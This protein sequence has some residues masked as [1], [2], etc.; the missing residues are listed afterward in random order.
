[1]Q[2][3]K[4][5]AELVAW[6]SWCEAH[7]Y[8]DFDLFAMERGMDEGVR[9]E[10]MRILE[11]GD[12]LPRFAVDANISQ[13][14]TFTKELLT[15]EF[16][17]RFDFSSQ[18]GAG[19]MGSVWLA[20]QTEPIQR[21]VAV[22]L[23]RNDL[24]SGSMRKRFAFEQ[25]ALASL[26]HQNIAT[27]HEAGETESGRSYFVMEY[28]PGEKITDYCNQYR[29]N[30][31]ARLELF[32]QVCDAVE[33]A[34]RKRMIHRDLKPSNVIVM[35]ENGEP[36]A[37][38]IDFGLAKDVT[39]VLDS[40]PLTRTNAVIGSPMWMSPEQARAFSDGEVQVDTR[41]DVYSLGVILYEL[42]TNS[43]P[44]RS[45]F[46]RSAPPAKVFDAIRSQVPVYPSNRL[47]A[48]QID[49]K[50]W[51]ESSSDSNYS[52]W[53]GSLKN[54]L[55]WVVM[56]ALEKEPERRYGTISEFVNDLKRFMRG[57][58]VS[59]RPPS[60]FYQ[61][62]KLVGRNRLAV[63]SMAVVTAALLVSVCVS[64]GYAIKADHARI[65]AEK[66]L[67][68]SEKTIDG[69]CSGFEVFSFNDQSVEN[70]KLKRELIIKF[71][72][73]VDL[74]LDSLRSE[75]GPQELARL[76]YV[77]GQAFLK[78]L[79][80]AD[81]HH[82][83]VAQ[84]R[85]LIA[86]LSPLVEPD[87]ERLVRSRGALAS[88][89]LFLK[90]RE[91][92]VKIAEENFSIIKR[93][94]DSTDY[95][96]LVC[97][98]MWIAASSDTRALAENLDMLERVVENLNLIDSEDGYSSSIEAMDLASQLCIKAS[99]YD[100]AINW[101]DKARKLSRRIHGDDIKTIQLD[102]KHADYTMSQNGKGVDLDQL[103]TNYKTVLDRYGESHPV[104]LEH[105]MFYGT[106]LVNTETGPLDE[107]IALIRN[108]FEISEKELGKNHL[109]TCKSRLGLV[110]SLYF[111]RKYEQARDAYET[112]AEDFKRYSSTTREYEV[113]GWLYSNALLR[114][115]EFEP[116]FKVAKQFQ[117]KRGMAKALVK[118]N[119]LGEAMKILEPLSESEPKSAAETAELLV[120][121][122]QIVS[123][124]YAQGN[125]E[126][127][128]ETL[129]RH[130]LLAPTVYPLTH[131]Y[132]IQA[133]ALLQ[134]FHA[135]NGDRE[136]SVR[137][138]LQLLDTLDSLKNNFDFAKASFFSACVECLVQCSLELGNYEDV[139]RY[140]STYLEYNTSFPGVPSMD[141]KL[142]ELTVEAKI[143]QSKYKEAEKQLLKWLS[144]LAIKQPED[145]QI[146]VV[147]ARKKAYLLMEKVYSASG[148][149][150]KA[151]E[152]R[153]KANELAK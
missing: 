148:Q 122:R 120:T 103:A 151:I 92:S 47:S 40:E 53:V 71:G 44:M 39:N 125:L 132:C 59:A 41:T 48:S 126:K 6:D 66:R 23:I 25:Q 11:I 83:I 79:R 146:D 68:I 127:A 96:Y 9:S 17:N 111:A 91:D 56:K 75:L 7:E 8:A 112:Y 117:D 94:F 142:N 128:I 22:K 82:E 61:F 32:L 97:E 10:L 42:L 124:F 16:G 37:K 145:N 134:Q 135:E 33:H 20:E 4:I 58:S 1:M 107:G 84:L 70:N 54:D 102:L 100:L 104:T 121:L 129:N 52:S 101:Y 34:H 87:D 26:S 12:N 43:T 38:V 57:E 153:L 15:K 29:L 80:S 90:K 27:V 141:A 144:R 115:G 138:G 55:D 13:S 60:R 119:R 3:N 152:F 35:E 99:E 62:K 73:R 81:H 85:Q 89:L 49:S 95:L 74:E 143:R 106:F 123:V 98:R 78:V 110:K 130:Q 150:A 116:S 69:F 2:E 31:R 36:V 64:T 108:A 113:A 24:V 50:S 133:Q 131:K 28:I 118:L 63:A 51:V 76:E 86:K 65:L 137:I 136:D 67:E 140:A 72:N 109:I 30:L 19:G 105:Q 5:D 139:D 18:L 21:N 77:W 149:Q 46:V 45:E 88:C 114:L 93:Q 14:D 147:D